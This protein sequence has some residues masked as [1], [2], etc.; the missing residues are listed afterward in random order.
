MMIETLVIL[1][2]LGY[3][4]CFAAVVIKAIFDAEFDDVNPSP[5]AALATLAMIAFWPVL[6]PVY[7]IGSLVTDDWNWSAGLWGEADK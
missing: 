1:W 5:R 4:M 6:L 7:I 2:G 3:A